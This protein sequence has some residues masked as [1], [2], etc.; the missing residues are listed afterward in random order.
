MPPDSLAHEDKASQKKRAQKWLDHNQYTRSSILRY[1]EIFGRTF[2]SVGGE[3]TTAHFCSKLDLHPGMKVL[4][5]GVGTGGSAFYMARRYE[6]DVNGID[7]SNNMIGLAREYRDTMEAE[8]KHRVHFYVE[9]ASTMD[10]PANFYDVIYSRDTILHISDKLGLFEKLLYCLKPGGKLMISDYCHGDKDH[11]QEFRDY[12][13]GRGY[14]LH[15]VDQYGSILREAGFNNVVAQD[16]TDEMI[17]ILTN[18]LDKF[19]KIHDKFVIQ[20]SEDDYDYIT[21]GWQKKI[22]SCRE[23]DQT[24]GVFTATK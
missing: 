23:G 10:Y 14:D 8:V 2:V 11:S 15:T 9:D 1:E 20:F 24:W 13:E 6:V 7:L 12:V 16:K 19:A 18:E 17:E 21:T 5:L 3:Q 22:R 4:D